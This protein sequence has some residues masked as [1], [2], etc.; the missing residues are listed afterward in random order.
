MVQVA[1]V[2]NGFGIIVELVWSESIECLEA[3]L[4][5]LDDEGRA[6][7]YISWAAWAGVEVAVV[8]YRLAGRARHTRA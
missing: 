6:A 8:K 4:A 2:T 3:G 1:W 7:L 5:V